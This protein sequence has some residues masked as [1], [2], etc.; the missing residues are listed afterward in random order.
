MDCACLE[1]ARLAGAQ[2]KTEGVVKQT[3][4]ATVLRVEHHL[5][6]QRTTMFKGL[7]VAPIQAPSEC[8]DRTDGP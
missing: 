6:A 1:T 5:H 8:Q 4:G 7:A 3:G 2:S